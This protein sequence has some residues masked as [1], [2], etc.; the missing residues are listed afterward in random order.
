MCVLSEPGHLCGWPGYL[1]IKKMSTTKICI[2]CGRGFV[3]NFSGGRPHESKEDFAKREY[4]TKTCATK[5]FVQA[6]ELVMIKHG[7]LYRTL[8]G[9]Y[10]HDIEQAQI[11]HPQIAE[12]I[13]NGQ[14]EATMLPLVTEKIIV[15]S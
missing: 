3:R 14:S 12:D 15:K 5:I 4:C 11:F 1:K 7:D 10:S 13:I 2:N 9:K 6:H 8:D